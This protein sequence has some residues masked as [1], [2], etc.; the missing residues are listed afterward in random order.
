MP[1]EFDPY[2]TWLGIPPEEQPP[3]YY[4]LL[5]IRP[6]EDDR[7]VITHAMDQRMAYL[8]TLQ[9]GKHSGDSQ[10]LLNEISAAAVVL[11]DPPQK[12][13]Y[14]TPLREKLAAAAGPPPVPPPI[15]DDVAP[16]PVARASQR[17]T[18]PPPQLAAIGGGLVL[19]LILLAVVTV[20]MW[21]ETAEVAD[22]PPVRDTS[23]DPARV[24][25][26]T[27]SPEADQVSEGSAEEPSGAPATQLVGPSAPSIPAE[28]ENDLPPVQIRPQPRGRPVPMVPDAPLSQPTPMP[29]PPPMPTPALPAETLVEPIAPTKQLPT[30][31]QVEAA[32]G[33][34][35]AIFGSEAKEADKP[36]EKLALAERI[37]QVAR[38]TSNDPAVK[39]ALLDA[40]RRLYAAAGEVDPA[41]TAADAMAETLDEDVWELRLGSVLAVADAPM[42]AAK[43]DRLAS[44]VVTLVDQAVVEEEFGLAEDLARLAIKAGSRSADA[45]VRRSVVQKR[46]ELTRLK[47]FWQTVEQAREKLVLDE[48]DPAAN[49]IV[50]KFLCFVIADFEQGIPHLVRSGREPYASTAIADLAAAAG[51]PEGGM[52]A[53]DAWYALAE[54]I[55]TSDKELVPGALLR[56]RQWYE[57]VFPQLSGLDKARIEKRIQETNAAAAAAPPPQPR[58][59]TSK[60]KRGK[61]GRRG[62]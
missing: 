49:L 11:L 25:I 35:L 31:E 3:H 39:Y 21:P 27:A 58:P 50:G 42:P 20:R 43:R 57:R 9:S 38:E 16:P 5:G 44:V 26:T 29:M 18:F 60:G 46:S 53:G 6:L 52:T 34:V 45:A 37:S 12:A 23:Q 10:R 56:A 13:R 55:R 14:D 22:K 7:D 48:E 33:K 47:E 1:A 8:R 2:Y 51:T 59:G 54:S 15:A 32:R 17:F 62:M 19:L 61:R 30:A 40:A 24:A 41:L 28:T 4:R 36:E